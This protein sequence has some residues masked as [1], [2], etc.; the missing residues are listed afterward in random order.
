MSIS[1]GMH[2]Q[3]RSAKVASWVGKN[4]SQLDNIVHA[5]LSEENKELKARFSMLDWAVQNDALVW[6]DNVN[7]TYAEAYAYVM[8]NP[9]VL[10]AVDCEDNV[11]FN[12][13]EK[14]VR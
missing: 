7:V 6:V 5:R 13:S 12:P 3:L 14:F 10:V 11:V 1:L 8:D 4:P 9:T 2:K